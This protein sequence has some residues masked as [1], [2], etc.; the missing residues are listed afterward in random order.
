[1]SD[2]RDSNSVLLNCHVLD[3]PD[4]RPFS[5][6][7]V[8]TRTV[9]QLKE[10]I[11]EHGPDSLQ[12][13]NAPNFD[14]W[15]V[16]V[17]RDNKEALQNLKPDGDPLNPMRLISQVFLDE[18]PSGYIHIVLLTPRLSELDILKRVPPSYNLT[19]FIHSTPTRFRYSK[20]PNEVIW[21]DTFLND[22]GLYTPSNKRV[23]NKNYFTFSE[24]ITV[25]LER[26]LQ[27]LLRR[28]VFETLG[29]VAKSDER[30]SAHKS[31]RGGPTGM[32]QEDP[33]LQETL[34]SLF[35][36]TIHYSLLSNS[37]P[38]ISYQ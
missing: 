34:I 1:M 9:S 31:T 8:T 14:L 7:I 12:G 22:V 30:F 38:H 10:L 18:I 24:G 27:Y 16:E 17:R 13:M 33:W 21:W 11:I 28:N 26:D 3:D 6:P 5:V 32:L 25:S 35:T 36:T 4:A 29:Q 23:Y 37:K 20:I 15:R 19:G 2:D